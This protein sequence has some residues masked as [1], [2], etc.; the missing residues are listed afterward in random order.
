MVAQLNI[1]RDEAQNRLDQM[2]GQVR[3]TANQTV[4]TVKQAAD[5]AARGLSRAS[6]AAIVALVLGAAAAAWGGHAGARRRLDEADTA[7]LG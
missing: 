6:L 1:S 3:Q 2:A 5:K 7:E 4:G